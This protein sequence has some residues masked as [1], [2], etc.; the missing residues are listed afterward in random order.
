M[1][2]RNTVIK[3]TDTQ[4]LVIL[5]RP[6]CEAEKTESSVMCDLNADLQAL[7]SEGILSDTEIRTATKTFPAHTQILG[8]RS[9]V[10]R[11]MFSKEEGAVE[12]VDIP[13]LDDDTVRLMLLHMYTDAFEKDLP[14][15]KAFELY[16]AARKHGITSLKLKCLSFLLNHLSASNACEILVFA[17]EHKEECLKRT[18]QG[19]ILKNQEILL[20]NEWKHLMASDLQLAAETMY[21]NWRRS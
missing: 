20:S 17:D 19:Y 3:S 1:A 9:L 11:N 14:Y 18:V 12:Y 6:V 21:S 7:Y 5:Q 2:D 15:K 8:A 10:F 4:R 13:D 16:Q